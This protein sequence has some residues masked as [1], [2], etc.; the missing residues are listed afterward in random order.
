[1][2]NEK[3]DNTVMEA[4]GPSD[5]PIVVNL[6]GIMVQGVKEEQARQIAEEAA[7]R[8]SEAIEEAYKESIA[9]L[10]ARAGEL[11]GQLSTVT[12]ERDA[13][14]AEKEE[15]ARRAAFDAL[16]DEFAVAREARE[17]LYG[18]FTGIEVE[19]ARK[20]VKNMNRFSTK[21]DS[22]AEGVEDDDIQAMSQ[23]YEPIDNDP[24]KL[25]ESLAAQF[26]P[27]KLTGRDN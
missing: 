20:L 26:Q 17:E 23:D 15:N 19:A 10:E 9:T 27:Y 18:A 6:E 13:L 14:L 24:M 4:Q 1:M 7:K 22:T 21:A 11:E 25:A 8:A 3:V 16:F 5:Q 12:A 2:K